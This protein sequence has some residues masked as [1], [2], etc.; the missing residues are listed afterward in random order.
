MSRADVLRERLFANLD[1]LVEDVEELVDAT[2]EPSNGAISSLHQR[3]S[4]SLATAKNTVAQVKKIFNA[5]RE[6]AETVVFYA[7][8]HCWA[9]IAIKI[10]AV[11][12]L[13]CIVRHRC[14][15]N[16]PRAE[17]S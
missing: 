1:Q 13:A 6:G 16:H 10:G 2:S 3:I 14:H 7:R 5:S 4:Q 8:Q 12:A 11:M 9:R 15:G 17:D